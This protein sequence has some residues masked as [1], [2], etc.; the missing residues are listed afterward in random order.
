MPT[1]WQGGY[2]TIR[3]LTG[4]RMRRY[5]NTGEH[6]T[7]HFFYDRARCLSASLRSWV[8]L[9]GP[10]GNR[11]T[12]GSLSA[13]QECRDT[14]RGRLANIWLP[15][16][17]VEA[18][19]VPRGC[20]CIYSKMRC[21]TT[22]QEQRIS[23]ALENSWTVTLRADKRVGQI[24][25]DPAM[26]PKAQLQRSYLELGSHPS[27]SLHPC[28]W[29]CF[30]F[31][32]D[33]IGSKICTN[34]LRVCGP[35]KL[36]KGW[37]AKQ[38]WE[39]ATRLRKANVHD[40]SYL[41]VLS[42]VFCLSSNKLTSFK[43]SGSCHKAWV[44]SPW[45][46]TGIQGRALL[47]H[48]FLVAHTVASSSAVPRQDG[49]V[50]GCCFFPLRKCIFFVAATFWVAKLDF[51]CWWFFPASASF[52]LA[53]DGFFPASDGFFP[54]PPKCIFSAAKVLL[55]CCKVFF[56]LLWIFHAAKRHFLLAFFPAAE[57]AFS[58]CKAFFSCCQTCFFPFRC[59]FLLRTCVFRALRED[60]EL[61]KRRV[62]HWAFGTCK[63]DSAWT[64][65]WQRRPNIETTVR[66]WK[67]ETCSGGRS[68]MFQ[69]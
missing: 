27:P 23:C 35:N 11:T 53:S 45:V 28:F 41:R 44:N 33:T 57:T 31:A 64:N 67:V 46:T 48:Q 32:P 60:K 30:P 29:I 4:S 68:D 8:L 13:T 12:T 47:C 58:R 18:P 15:K 43:G 54:L 39:S 26:S 14:T 55:C 62:I 69:R 5:R 61:E 21:A 22:E 20:W 24:P 10:A 49:T 65:R 38:L 19:S 40:R 17:N 52:F 16:S 1:P 63:L 34:E 25:F 6:L 2:F 59:F 50:V 42:G 37:E 51:L 66:E 7:S 36:K 3:L 9:A 56:L